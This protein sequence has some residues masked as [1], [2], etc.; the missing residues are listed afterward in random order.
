[1]FHRC[2]PVTEQTAP[3]RGSTINI[4]YDSRID[5][6][7]GSDGEHGRPGGLQ[8]ART[9]NDA[10][11][12]G[13]RQASRRLLKQAATN[14]NGVTCSS[15]R[16]TRGDTVS[17]S[18]ELRTTVDPGTAGR[19]RRTAPSVRRPLHLRMN[20]RIPIW[21]M[22]ATAAQ[23]DP[24]RRRRSSGAAATSCPRYGA[25]RGVGGSWSERCCALLPSPGTDL[26]AK[27]ITSFQK[28]VVVRGR[29]SVGR[30]V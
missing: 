5:G 11:V 27:L 24:R 13:Q 1:M 30:L 12:R 29:L 4:S 23:A 21:R 25:R 3:E 26:S 9:R 17:S 15:S 22:S 6:Q 18:I 16:D 19:R 20:R 10:G 14:V 7:R 8:V 28:P 2:H